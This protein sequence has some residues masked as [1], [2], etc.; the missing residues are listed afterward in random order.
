[1]R[2]TRPAMGL[3]VGA[4]LEFTDEVTMSKALGGRHEV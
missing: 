3:P 4:D 2:V 1:V